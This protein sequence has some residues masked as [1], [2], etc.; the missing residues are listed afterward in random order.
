MAMERYKNAVVAD[1]KYLPVRRTLANRYRAENHPDEAIVHMRAI[2][3]IEPERL[4]NFFEL[5]RY[6]WSLDRKLDALAAYEQAVVRHPKN[7]EA[8]AAALHVAVEAPS[9]EKGMTW[10]VQLLQLDPKHGMGTLDQARLK[11][12]MGQA[13][14]ALK[15]ARTAEGLLTADEAKD[16][17][18]LVQQQAEA[19]LAAPK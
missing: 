6:L 2:T 1:A 8:L 18:K 5:G 17:A 15:L 11:L 16:Q 7:V 12:A 4:E 3:E 14:E 19:A 10:A 9:T 13:K